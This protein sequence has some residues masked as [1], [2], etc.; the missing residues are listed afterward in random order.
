MDIKLRGGQDGIDAARQ[1]RETSPVPVV[2]LTANSDGSMFSRAKDIEPVGYL[3]KPY[4]TSDLDAV[5]TLALQQ[6]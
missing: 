3:T 1:I 6:H 5:V 2:F 4:R